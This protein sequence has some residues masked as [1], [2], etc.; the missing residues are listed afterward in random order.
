[1][2]SMGSLE[3]LALAA[4]LGLTACGGDKPPSTDRSSST[5]KPSSITVTGTVDWQRAGGWSK[6]SGVCNFIGSQPLPITISDGS[7]IVAST[8]V[9]HGRLANS[10]D[11]I[12]RFKF[13][14][15]AAGASAY[16]ISAF[17]TSTTWIPAREIKKP[18]S[19]TLTQ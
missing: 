6:S 11:C 15:V 16:G 2:R 7:K 17:N 13:T 5:D 10:G 3:V 8:S 4:V 9:A 1:M 18:V 12:F 14:G 19:L